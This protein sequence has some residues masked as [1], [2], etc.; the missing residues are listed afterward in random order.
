MLW[1]TSFHLSTLSFAFS[2]FLFSLEVAWHHTFFMVSIKLEYG[3]SVAVGYERNIKFHSCR[4]L[5]FFENV[6]S[7]DST[8]SWLLIGGTFRG[9]TFHLKD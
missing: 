9:K 8:A 3:Q 5:F 4:Q 1:I 6:A 7:A 2:S